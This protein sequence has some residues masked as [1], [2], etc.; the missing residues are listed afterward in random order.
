MVAIA[1]SI[2][3]RSSPWEDDDKPSLIQNLKVHYSNAY[4]NDVYG[5]FDVYYLQ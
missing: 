4:F 2:A 1:S 5:Y 3:Q